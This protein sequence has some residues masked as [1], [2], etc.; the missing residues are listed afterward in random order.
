MSKTSIRVVGMLLMLAL[1]YYVNTMLQTKTET[2]FTPQELEAAIAAEGAVE[3]KELQLTKAVVTTDGSLLSVQID[4]GGSLSGVPAKGSAVVRGTPNYGAARHHFTFWVKD[5]QVENLTL[6]GAGGTRV[7]PESSRHQP[8][9]A[10]SIGEVVRVA[11]ENLR[12]HELHPDEVTVYS[13]L[14]KVSVQNDQVKLE[15]SA[16]QSATTSLVVILI[17][18]ILVAVTIFCPELWIWV[19]LLS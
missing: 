1:A 12:A 6:G 2:T 11:F 15:F 3:Y 16:V 8:N 18:A 4:F 17:I 9:L 5:V 10:S 14:N 7:A 13:W 19:F